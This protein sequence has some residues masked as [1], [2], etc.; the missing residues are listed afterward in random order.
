MIT[1]N[2]TKTIYILTD[3]DTDSIYDYDNDSYLIFPSC[4][5]Y[6]DRWCFYKNGRLNKVGIFESYQDAV[7][8]VKLK[9]DSV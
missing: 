5:I 7:E 8:Y 4:D 6:N 2:Y 3:P 9:I 1:I